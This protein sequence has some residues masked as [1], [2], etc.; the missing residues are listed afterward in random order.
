M[1]DMQKKIGAALAAVN[2]YLQDEEAMIASRQ[3]AGSAPSGPQLQI[4][5]W[6]QCG[7]QEMMEMRR[8]LQ[9]RA[10]SRCR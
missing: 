5:L 2:T 3:Q 4:S 9:M 7:R 10:I 1:A 8:L 6:S